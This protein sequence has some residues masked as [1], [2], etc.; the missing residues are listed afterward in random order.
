MRKLLI[1]DPTLVSLLGHSYNYDRAIFEAARDVFDE[2]VLYADKRFNEPL[3]EGLV[4][5]AVLNRL[6]IDTLKRWVNAAFHPFR[7][8]TGEGAPAGANSP[9]STVVPNVWQWVIRLAKMMRVL[10]LQGS[11][12]Q[13]MR[14]HGNGELHV[15]LQHAH[16][17][18]LIV[19]DRLRRIRGPGSATQWLHL[20]L[21]YSPELV[22]AGFFSEQEFAAL[23][24][25][26]GGPGNLKVQLLTDSERL[27]A[28]Y[29]AVG[30]DNVGTLPVPIL[31]PEEDPVADELAVVNVSFL[32]S[33]RV[34]KGFCEL[35]ALVSALP[36]EAG[37]RKIRA[38]VQ[39]TRDSADPRVRAAVE[40]LRALQRAM[41]EALELLDSPVPVP[42]Y[43]GWVA[44]SGIVALPYLSQ[45]YNAST[46]G[47]FVE[48]ICFGVPVLCP[49]SSWMSDVVE[50]AAREHGLRIGEVFSGLGEIGGLV[51][52]IAGETARYRADV[53]EFAKRWRATHNPQACVRALVAAT[54]AAAE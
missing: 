43:F 41:P 6:P 38:M 30:V 34:E 18:E 37:G 11:L 50:A 53:R 2:V 31:L 32:G 12:E 10:D 20:V 26:L 28:E 15:L 40:S 29:R 17:P 16:L 19:A 24:R 14:N 27:S 47:I 8:P 1:V 33:S 49:S 35:P 21:R 51:S 39:I 46:S 52:R 9:H 22:N 36:R 5:R 42:V 23:L 7:Q 48:A 54:R 13:I 4:C 25:R 44:R 45:K 3:P